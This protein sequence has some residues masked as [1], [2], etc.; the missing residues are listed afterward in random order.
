MKKW[1]VW[2]LLTVLTLTL[3][4]GSYPVK[5]GEKVLFFGDSITHGGRYIAFLQLLLDSQG[6]V[7]DADLMNAG[8]SGGTAA[9]GLRRIQHD[10]IDR[11]PDRVFILFGMNDVGRTAYRTDTPSNLM[12]RKNRLNIYTKNQKQ[13]I[14]LLKDAGITPVLMTPTAFDQYQKSGPADHCNEPGLSDIANIVRDLAKSEGVDLIEL[15]PYM[16]DMLKKH[17]DLQLCGKDLVHPIHIA[18]LVMAC[19]IAEQL[20]MTGPVADVTIPASGTPEARFAKVTD[21]QSANGKIQFRYT[22]ERLAITIPQWLYKGDIDVIY[23]FTEKWNRETLRLTGLADGKY[24]VKANGAQLGTFSAADLAKGIDLAKLATPNA[25]RSM[26][27]V[28]TA[29]SLFSINSEL[30]TLEQCRGLIAG[31]KYGN[32]DPKDYKAMSEAMDKW[33]ADHKPDW[34]YR[35]YYTNQV[36]NY[37]KNAPLEADKIAGREDLRRQLAEDARPVAYTI[38]VE[39]VQ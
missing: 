4:A 18:H 22:P 5:P 31:G 32:P 9:G 39:K 26:K 34:P 3:A 15:H 11:K 38:S 12:L 14:K 37:R 17:P 10:V 20:G 36:N 13:V 35:K 6:V 24:L 19:L 28:K 29:W 30:R 8:I 7:T 25:G 16:T 27:A 1:C 33:L 2:L 21:L 23:P